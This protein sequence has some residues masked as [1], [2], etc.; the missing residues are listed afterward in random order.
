MMAFALASVMMLA[1]GCADKN[2]TLPSKENKVALLADS[3]VEDLIPNFEKRDADIGILMRDETVKSVLD[4]LNNKYSTV[5]MLK[6]KDANLKNSDF[7]V[8]TAKDLAYYV[9]KT[10]YYK[11]N[12]DQTYTKNVISHVELVRKY[13]GK[14]RLALKGHTTLLKALSKLTQY[15]VN[16]TFNNDV[17]DTDVK[18]SVDTYN[19]DEYIAKVCTAGNVWYEFDGK[20][21]NIFSTKTFTVSMP[22]RGTVTFSVGDSGGSSGGSSGGGDELSLGGGDSG[23][24]SGGSAKSMSYS[25]NNTSFEQ[26]IDQLQSR[27]DVPMY[28]S[29]AGFYM[30]RATP[31]QYEVLNDYFDEIEKR[32]EQI[33]VDLQLLRIDLKDQYKWGVDWNNLGNIALGS[34]SATFNG[35]F[36]TFTDGDVKGGFNILN[37]DGSVLGVIEAVNEFGE[38]HKVDS[39]YSQMMTGAVLPFNKFELVRYFTIGSTSTQTSSEVTYEVQEDE[40]GFKGSVA[41]TKVKHGYAVDGYIELSAVTDYI[42]QALGGD[43]GEITAPIIQ[44]N[45]LKI[46][47]RISQLN[48]TIVAVGFRTKGIQNKDRGLPYLQDLP[49]VGYF[50]GNKDNLEQNSE[51]IVLLTIREPNEGVLKENGKNNHYDQR[52]FNQESRVF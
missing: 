45:S 42:T 23:G 34:K 25:I 48:R 46:E 37:S 3:P 6:S 44:G 11:L 15:K 24:S 51:F 28:P 18:V 39:Y 19:F 30:F 35:N 41:V 5:Y 31:L 33:V 21:L 43:A 50:F 8:K 26:L 27:F 12:I 40:V 32:R 29:T 38:V 13:E 20:N 2:E 10:T 16:I 14:E 36:N 4:K 52:L 47:T 17:K 1:S 49:L 9:D 7:R 22:V